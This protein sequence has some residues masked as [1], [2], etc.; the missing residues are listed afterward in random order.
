MFSDQEGHSSAAGDKAL[1]RVIA[2]NIWSF[3]ETNTSEGGLVGQVTHCMYK[4]W[5][6]FYVRESVRGIYSFFISSGERWGDK[7]GRVPRHSR[8][9]LELCAPEPWWKEISDAVHKGDLLKRRVLPNRNFNRA[10]IKE[11][12][13]R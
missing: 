7:V 4:N 5:I 9:V 13:G 1:I 3:G 2:I 12:F 8:Q 6:P 11:I 10:F